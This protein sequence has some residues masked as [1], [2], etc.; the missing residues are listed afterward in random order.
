MY[1]WKEK[2]I[3]L[4]KVKNKLFYTMAITCL[5]TGIKHLNV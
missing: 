5:L 4:K 3:A 1:G 2:K